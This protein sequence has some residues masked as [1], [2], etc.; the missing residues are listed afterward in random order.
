MDPLENSLFDLP[1]YEHTEDEDFP[2]LPAPHSPGA[3]DRDTGDLEDDWTKS[4]GQKNTEEEP[5]P[6]RRAVKRPQPKL[7]AVRL[8][9]QRGLPALR[10][11]FENTKFKGKGHEAEDLKVL[12]RQMENW[13]NRLFPKLQFEEFLSR[14]ETLGNKKEV[15]TCLK[16]IRMDLPIVHEDFNSE[17]VVVQMEDN[18]LDL[19]SEDFPAPPESPPSLSQPSTAELS[20]ETLQRIERNRQLALEKRMQKMQAQ[21]D[22]QALAPSQPPAPDLE[23]IPE[24]F[25]VDLLEAVD[26]TVETLTP[27]LEL[28][29][30]PV[31]IEES[32]TD[33]EQPPTEICS[34]MSNDTED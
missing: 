17:E 28:P 5:K 30:S 11:L 3:L 6:A 22:S 9:S 15:Q 4:M 12:I 16:R 27:P 24:D 32:P 20:E 26:K 31:R 34:E 19:A 1:D 23:D 21:V 10:H 14:L 25:D 13:A 29:T 33:Q 2:P 8:T 18:N 7:D